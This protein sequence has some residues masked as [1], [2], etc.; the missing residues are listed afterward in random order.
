MSFTEHLAAFRA[1]HPEIE[2]AEVYVSDLNG[3]A[4]G[5]VE[6]GA[7]VDPA[8]LVEGG[9]AMGIELDQADALPVLRRMGAQAGIGGEMIA[10]QAKRGSALPDHM[11][12]RRLDLP[13]HL[14]RVAKIE[15]DIPPIDHT[16][17][18]ERVKGRGPDMAP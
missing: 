13:R 17:A 3:V 11:P 12:N 10:A 18:F 7:V 15:V 2:V 8:S 9:I 4:R 16:H 1:A 5:V 14:V 6:H